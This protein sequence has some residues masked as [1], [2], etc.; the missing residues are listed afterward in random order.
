[1]IPPHNFYF[2]IGNFTR[3]FKII[4]TIGT[5]W[6]LPF[7]TEGRRTWPKGAPPINNFVWYI[8]TTFILPSGILQEF[9]LKKFQNNFHHRD[10]VIPTL[11]DWGAGVWPKGAPA[12]NPPKLFKPSHNP[13]INEILTLGWFIM[14]IFIIIRIY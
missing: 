11:C 8:I 5:P 12:P 6:Y 2:T 14:L 4:F 3:N 1:M 10:A 9:Q 7:V 13:P